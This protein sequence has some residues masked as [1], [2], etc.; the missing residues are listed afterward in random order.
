[1]LIKKL[2]SPYSIMF[3]YISS[4]ARYRIYY[5]KDSKSEFQLPGK[6]P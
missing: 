6:N 5:R 2:L 4:E 3:E 1:M